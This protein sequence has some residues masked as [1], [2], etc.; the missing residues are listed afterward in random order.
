MFLPD[1]DDDDKVVVGV[2]SSSSSSSS[3][4]SDD[5]DEDPVVARR[6]NKLE[7]GRRN[8]NKGA[9]R[10]SGNHTNSAKSGDDE[11]E[12]DGSSSSDVEFD[13][14][15]K[16]TNHVKKNSLRNNHDLTDSDERSYGKKKKKKKKKSSSISQINGDSEDCASTSA[17][18]NDRLDIFGDDGVDDFENNDSN[19]DVDFDFRAS[20]KKT[21]PSS[22]RGHS[23]KKKSS[24]NKDDFVDLGGKASGRK[25]K[26]SDSIFQIDGDSEDNDNVVIDL[27]SD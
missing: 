6:R 11:F 23:M 17:K 16:K 8:L 22:S 7:L 2:L 26:D 21:K 10:S 27:A 18:K 20:K 3:S 4:T 14:G 12:N 5:S 1:T 25:K 15:A 19:S 13:F 24:R 9:F